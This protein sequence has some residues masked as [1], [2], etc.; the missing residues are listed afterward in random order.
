MSKIRDILLWALLFGLLWLIGEYTFLRAIPSSSVVE[1]QR[2]EPVQEVHKLGERPK[3]ATRASYKRPWKI[4][5]EDIQYCTY[6]WSDQ[7]VYYNQYVTSTTYEESKEVEWWVWQYD[8]VW[9]LVNAKCFL[10]N[11]TTVKLNYWVVK[12]DVLIS[13]PYFYWKRF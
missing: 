7:T 6:E 13:W 10:K 12:R 2:I 3:F 1:M 9:P 4:T 11:I 8:K 5:W